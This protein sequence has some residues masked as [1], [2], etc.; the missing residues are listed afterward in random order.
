MV[1]RNPHHLYLR[2]S[3]AQKKI[4]YI[5]LA[6]HDTDGSILIQLK[7]KYR[8]TDPGKS[9]ASSGSNSGS[10]KRKD[11]NKPNCFSGKTIGKM[12]RNYDPKAR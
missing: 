8:S 3:M 2:R 6:S 4:E 1:G 12:L 9:K 11:K 10:S 7:K 5:N